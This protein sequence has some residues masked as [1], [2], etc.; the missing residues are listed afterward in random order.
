[1]TFALVITKI[2][3]LIIMPIS[4]LLR[5]RIAIEKFG[6]EQYKSLSGSSLFTKISWKDTTNRIMGIGLLLLETIGMIA[7]FVIILSSIIN[8]AKA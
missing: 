3:I 8:Y 4:V 2:L 7:L 5:S 6:L 1:M